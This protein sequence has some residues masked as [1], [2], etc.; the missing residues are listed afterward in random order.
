MTRTLL[1]R[2][3]VAVL[4]VA[5]AAATATPTVSADET[6]DA[7]F[8]AYWGAE[9]DGEMAAAA[10]AILAT[11]APVADVWAK[12]ETGRTYADSIAKGRLLLSRDNRDGVA[13]AYVLHVPESYDPATLYPVRVYLHGG[14]MRPLRIDGEWWPRNDGLARDDALVVFPASWADSIWWHG[15]QLENLVGLLNDLKRTYNVDENRVH[16]LGVS[17]GATGAY[18]QAFKA[19]T[20]W[21]GFLPFNG[22]PAVLSN[23]TSDVDGDMH[24]TNLRNKPFFVV[25]GANDR[26][27]PAGSVGQYVRLFLEAGGVVDFRPQADSGHDMR[28]W[29]REASSI[30]AF[31]QDTHRV[32]LPDEL[33]WETESVEEFNRAHWLVIDEL[34]AV[35]GES[36]LDPFNTLVDQGARAPLG[37]NM[38]GELVNRPGLRLLDVG[39]E[40][41]AARS[42]L[43][44]DD[45]IVAIDGVPTPDVQAFRDAI[46]G[47]APGQQLPIR[48]ERSGVQLG[49]T[50]NYPAAP[51]ARTRPAFRRRVPSGR[52]DLQRQGN[53]VTVSTQGVRRFTLLLSPA[54][55]DLSQP[56]RVVT[57][58][59]VSHDGVVVPEVAT[60]L[61]WAAVDQDRSLLFTAELQ[62]EVEPTPR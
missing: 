55:F 60:L 33:S 19:T 11:R 26:L 46:V 39:P 51:E 31:V 41:I 21:A 59:V 58:G 22:H 44:V 38:L 47:F 20:P 52:V 62:I 10:E 18:Y 5:C 1:S 3:A 34:G 57:N 25:N 45:V 27:Y 49:L 28:W 42:G 35:D 54:Q 7:A 13:H 32:P 56:I 24:V 12:L 23:P 61:R 29:P 37:I 17:D 43:V 8:A 16:L 50:L 4:A 14:V 48:I 6:L 36:E 2:L 53:T 40:S 15:S 9:T 30:D